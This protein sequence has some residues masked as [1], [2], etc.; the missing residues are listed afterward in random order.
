[1]GLSSSISKHTNVQALLRVWLMNLL[2]VV[3]IS[4]LNFE[5]DSYCLCLRLIWYMVHRPVK[6]T[7]WC[8]YFLIMYVAVRH[9]KI[10]C[11]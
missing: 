7:G 8:S 1:M 11:C 5:W 3:G 10:I 4:S 2:K 6:Y 9:K